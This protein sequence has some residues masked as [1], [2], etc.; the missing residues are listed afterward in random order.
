MSAPKR[1][2]GPNERQKERKYNQSHNKYH[3]KDF[4]KHKDFKQSL[5]EKSKAFRK[6]QPDVKLSDMAKMKDVSTKRRTYLDTSVKTNPGLGS[7]ANRVLRKQ[8]VQG[9]DSAYSAEKGRMGEKFYYLDHTAE[10][11]ENYRK[12]QENKIFDRVLHD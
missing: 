3:I 9:V 6:G 1:Y 11:L 8:A 12:I 10:V 2:F 4:T 5:D 7:F